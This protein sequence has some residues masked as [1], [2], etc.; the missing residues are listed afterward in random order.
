MTEIGRPLQGASDRLLSKQEAAD[1]T[2]LTVSELETRV[3]W[4]N[5]PR[6]M[7]ISPKK[8]AF[9][10]SDLDAWIASWEHRPCRSDARCAACLVLA[11]WVRCPRRAER[12]ETGVDDSA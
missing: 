11:D 7:K 6:W 3:R 10:L 2:G 9:R 4:G 5:G 8:V 1:Y 12:C